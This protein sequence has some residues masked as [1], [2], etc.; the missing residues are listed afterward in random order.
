MTHSR[1]ICEP[2]RTNYL[3]NN[4]FAT[5]TR[6][7]TDPSGNTPSGP[8]PARSHTP[9]IKRETKWNASTRRSS[10]SLH[11]MRRHILWQTRS[12]RPGSDKSFSRPYRRRPHRRRFYSALRFIGCGGTLRPIGVGGGFGFGGAVGL[13][14]LK[15][16]VLKILGFSWIN[17]Q[18]WVPNRLGPSTWSIE[19]EKI[20]VAVE[21][22]IVYD[23]RFRQK[24]E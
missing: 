13:V 7:E 6:A 17:M 24:K 22:F 23:S 4:K 3:A 2:I 21:N 11:R 9:Y 5:S 1:P 20:G 14:R 19:I 16:E 12:V 15:I 10:S 8:T 18:S